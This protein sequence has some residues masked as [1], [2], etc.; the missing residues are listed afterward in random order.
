MIYK[1]MTKLKNYMFTE[2]AESNTITDLSRCYNA[3]GLTLAVLRE[4]KILSKDQ[5]EYLSHENNCI[6]GKTMSRMTIVQSK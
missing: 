3:F 6:A 4:A 2:I 5:Y 1:E